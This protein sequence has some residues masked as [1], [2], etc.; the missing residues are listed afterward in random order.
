MNGRPAVDIVVPFLGSRDD[1]IDLLGRLDRLRLGD[2][3]TLTVVDNG[4][5]GALVSD[6]RVVPAR[7]RRSPS[8]ARNVGARKGS[9]EWLIFLDAD[10]EPRADLIDQYFL[11]A[12][13]A[14]DVGVM[15]GAIHDQE[16]PPG[17][18]RSAAARYAFL[19]QSMSQT[20]TR[21]QLGP[22]AKTANAAVRRVAFE[23]IGGFHDRL[24]YGEDVDLCYRLRAAG[25]R[26]EFRDDPIVEH[27]GHATV[28]AL[29][30]Q[31]ARHGSGAAW[32]DAE[33]PG[34][35]PPFT[36][37]SLIVSLVGGT[38]KATAAR[39]RGDRDGALIR[40]LDPL[41][42]LAFHLGRFRSNPEQ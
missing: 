10:V 15:A 20:N 3:D 6:A 23:A 35:S 33:Y 38:L 26:L 2:A 24:V 9:A 4:P 29:L 28:W 31:Q 37:S 13:P 19:R 7:E 18:R 40:F 14:P 27:L 42:A 41:T 25:W 36:W 22:F 12:E 16:P 30:A 1:M 21:A 39:L 5:G 34:F 11:P 8:Y 32:L 17:P